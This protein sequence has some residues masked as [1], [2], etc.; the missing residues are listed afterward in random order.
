MKELLLSFAMMLPPTTPAAAVPIPA[1]ALGTDAIAVCYDFG[2][3]TRDIISI[4]ARDWHEVAGWF[5]PP[6]TSA[7]AERDQI[8]QAV[9]WMEVVAGRHTPT[10]RDIGKNLGP[11]AEFPGQLD[12]IDESLNTTTYLKLFEANGLLR[13]HRV[14]ERAHR[15]AIFDQ[16]FAGQVEELDGGERWVIDT[17]FHDNG[18]LPYVQQTVQWKDL[19]LLF[20]SYSD[21]SSDSSG[22]GRGSRLRSLFRSD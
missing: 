7:A 17:W 19:P 8:R 5:S 2:C 21:N 6:A 20:S 22:R 4:S 16:H 18:V 3:K 10:F 9:G 13:W 12:C 1:A 15:R 14:V 11:G